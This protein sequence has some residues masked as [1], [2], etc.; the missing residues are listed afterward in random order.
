MP[1]HSSNAPEPTVL[2]VDNGSLAPAATLALRSLAARLGETTGHPVRPVSLLHSSAIAPDLLDGKPAHIL[3]PTLW[4]LAAAGKNNIVIL[5]LFFGPSAAVEE[6]I[7]DRVRHL[8]LTWPQLR[9]RLAPC[10]VDATQPDDHRIAALLA[11]RVRAVAH[12][13][14]F[15]HP[16]VAVVDHGT[17]QRA[18]NAVRN[19]V[20]AQMRVL[21]G[22]FARQVVACSMERRAEP[23]F[24]FN[25]PLLAILFDQNGFSAGEVIV[26]RLFLL[27]GR[28]A[29]PGG[30][31][32][33]ICRAATTRH[34]ELKIALTEP[35]GTHPGL[36]PIL[37]DRLN[38]GL[39]KPPIA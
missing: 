36:L 37:G 28:H 21:L 30:D 17:P 5:P 10:L 13:N 14:K 15:F 11:D 1:D 26:A 7:P 18:V 19:L 39:N 27:P 31:I 34:P 38:E 6:Y 32:E 20:A 35:L 23:E 16:A 24:D 25:E 3:E 29:G 22:G 4:A 33:T 8:L 9:V 12:E 2:L